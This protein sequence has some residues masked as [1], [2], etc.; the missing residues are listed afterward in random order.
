M[1]AAIDVAVI[2]A[3][4]N[5]LVAATF[6]GRAGLRVLLL[7]RETAVGGQGRVV[8]FAPGFRAAPLASDP[9]WLPPRVARAVGLEGLRRQPLD[10]PLTLALGEPG[11]S[12]TLWR[13]TAR[14]VEAIRRHSTADASRWPVFT[15]RVRKLAGFLEALYSV[16]APDVELP[17]GD[18]L[19][20]LGL[21]RR[22][23]G[24]GREDMIEFLRFLPTS[25]WELL[26]DTFESAALKA[27]VAAGGVRDHRQGPRSGATGFVLLHYLVGAAEG[28]VRGR[29]QWQG[30][31]ETFTRAAEAA[32]RAAG[33]VFRSG[34][35]VT[36][37]EVHDDA[38]TGVVLEDGEQIAARR[39]LSTADPART[40]LEWMDP[41]WL[42][43]EFIRAVR[44]V[45]FRGCTAYVLY[46]M[47][48]LPEVPGLSSEALGGVVS[49][50][51]S[52]EALERAADAAKYGQPSDRP[53]VE[54]SV[55]SVHASGLAPEGK[56]VLIARAQYAP[57][58]LR[59]GAAWDEA[60]RDRLADAV[61]TAIA[62]VVP[63]F[64]TRVLHRVA[65]TPRDLEDRFALTEGA[66]THGEMALDQILFMRPVAG[67]G[68]YAMPIQGLYLGGVGTHPGPGILG[69][70]GWLAARRLLSDRA[71]R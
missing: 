13:E 62:G 53:H 35:P 7:E 67:W 43:P 68:R 36:R 58:R 45:R 42:D 51:A 38:V 3:G 23:R 14:A 19:P 8:E 10:A 61:T 49:L 1:S 48:A 41:M 37:I 20:L 12:L 59:G 5:G 57:Y 56:H 47:D 44:A 2:G 46:A 22:F 60:R 17:R 65:W 25:V 28:V 54:F 21:A 4:T 32:A 9:G 63:C 33:V 34:A 64:G 31:P 11:A 6:L 27:A 15:A 69:G 50:T 40:L 18:W 30:G 39:V 26:D 66:P 29:G 70:S 24:L 16:P 52:L 71:Q 55:P